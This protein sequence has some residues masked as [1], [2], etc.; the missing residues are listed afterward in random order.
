MADQ[1]FGDDLPVD[2]AVEE[3]IR[4][5]GEDRAFDNRFWRGDRLRFR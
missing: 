1:R 3:D 5:G 2:D 4:S